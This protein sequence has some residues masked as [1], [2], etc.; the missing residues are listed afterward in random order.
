MYRRSHDVQP[1]LEKLR[2]VAI[3]SHGAGRSY[4][5]RMG[6]LVDLALNVQFDYSY[7]T[8]YFLK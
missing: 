3:T 6:S 5:W 1:F 2:E 8:F 7:G 4:G